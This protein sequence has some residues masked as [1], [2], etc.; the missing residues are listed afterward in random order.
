MR[1]DV[2]YVGL[3]RLVLDGGYVRRDG[4][5]RFDGGPREFHRGLEVRLAG[6]DGIADETDGDGEECGLVVVLGFDDSEVLC[7][8]VWGVEGGGFVDGGGIG[9]GGLGNVEFESRL[10]LR[11]LRSG[12]NELRREVLRVVVEAMRM[13]VGD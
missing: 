10:M 12:L 2:G 11:N 4:R 6:V 9:V 3:R 13:K 7:M 1:R 8:V 5:R